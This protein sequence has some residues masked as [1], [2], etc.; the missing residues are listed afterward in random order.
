MV[1]ALSGCQRAFEVASRRL[2]N[3]GEPAVRRQLLA[4]V[5]RQPGQQPRL[6]GLTDEQGP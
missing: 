5:D 6:P 2:W 3:D 1:L 4:Q